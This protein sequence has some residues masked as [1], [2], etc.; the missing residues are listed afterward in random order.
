[1]YMHDTTATDLFVL[2]QSFQSVDLIEGELD[3]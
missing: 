2:Q 3:K 1:M